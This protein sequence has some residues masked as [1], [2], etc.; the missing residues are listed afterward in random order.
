MKNSLV[1]LHDMVFDFSNMFVMKSHIRCQNHFNHLCSKFKPL[2]VCQTCQNVGTALVQNLE[3]DAQVVIFEYWTVIVERG[4]VGAR[5]D[6]VV[7]RRPRVRDVVDSRRENSR[8]KLQVVNP[9]L[10]RMLTRG[11]QAATFLLQMAFFY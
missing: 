5:P 11:R 3:S 2:V 7:V 4:E 1:G 8:E 9:G 6:V 10:K